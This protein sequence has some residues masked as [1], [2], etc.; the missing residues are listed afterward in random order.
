ML[1]FIIESYSFKRII[2]I[3]A[4]FILIF[5]AGSKIFDL[6]WGSTSSIPIINLKDVYKT[7]IW[8]DN[9]SRIN[10]TVLSRGVLCI[11]G[12]KKF[13]TPGSSKDFSYYDTIPFLYPETTHDLK[14]MIYLQFEDSP[15]IDSVI[16]VVSKSEDPKMFYKQ[17]FYSTVVINSLNSL[18]KY[19][20]EFRINKNDIVPS[21]LLQNNDSLIEL[22]FKYFNDNKDTLGLSE[23][24]TNS[25]IFKNICFK[26]NLPCRIVS[27]QGGDADQF[28]YNK[29]IGYPL[30][31]VCELY[32]S[33]H[34]KWYVV[35][36]S[37]GFRF[38]EANT[39]DYLS[40]V[41]ISNM[42]EFGREK[43]IIQD[44][45]LFTK[46]T[47]VGRDYFRFY[48]NVYFMVGM[49]NKIL[50]KI[51]RVFYPKFNF[52]MY[53]YSNKYPPVNNGFYYVGVK[54][55]MYF[56]ILIVYINSVMFILV[57]RLFSVKKPK[58]NQQ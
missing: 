25:E 42:Y 24:G 52:R 57:I 28:G 37:F 7:P 32:S 26:Y 4:L 29:Q 45:V 10:L 56:F 17:I 3:S 50:R 38:K 35:D 39:S 46:R 12:N 55:F 14:N 44:S 43:E 18:S 23:C 11:E 34:K 51:F 9:F 54:T 48:E 27:L 33:L 21:P 47:V 2:G 36:P 30:H 19:P 5:A 16:F 53:H 49:E 13:K 31:V 58:H 41:E 20:E 40:A 22:A 8:Y 6:I 15:G 1:R